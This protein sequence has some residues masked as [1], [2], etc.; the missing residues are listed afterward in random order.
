MTGTRSSRLFVLGFVCVASLAW[1]TSQVISAAAA[2]AAAAPANV[3]VAVLD[4]DAVRQGLAEAT[5]LTERLQKQKDEYQAKVDAMLKDAQNELDKAEALPPDQKKAQQAKVQELVYRAQFEKEWSQN[6][7]NRQEASSIIG[8]YERIDTAVDVVAKR[9]GYHLVLTADDKL[10]LK[11]SDKDSIKT[12]SA[13]VSM[14]RMLYA[15]P[16]IDITQQVI[17]YMNNEFKAGR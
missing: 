2:P 13:Y 7:L 12:V 5:A 8:L 6:L 1:C 3:R 14:R 15:D 11:N 4:L 10:A 17:D 9:E 16:A